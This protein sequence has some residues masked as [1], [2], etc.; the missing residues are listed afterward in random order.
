MT[1]SNIRKSADADIKAIR[2]WLE[3]E[4]SQGTEGNF[5][6]NWNLTLD[7]H[8]E[9]ELLVYIDPASGEPV[10]YQ[11]GALI[12]PGILQV[13]NAKATLGRIRRID[14]AVAVAGSGEE[15]PLSM[16]DGDGSRRPGTQ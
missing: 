6:C 11:W 12:Q 3:Q 8:S 16:V 15:L 14:D 1:E 2:R 5:L 4:E 7:A 9:G 13:R 10:A